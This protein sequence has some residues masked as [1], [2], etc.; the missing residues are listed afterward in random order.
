MGFGMTDWLLIGLLTAAIIFLALFLAYI[1]S[2]F[3]RSRKL[4]VFKEKRPKN[5]KKRKKWARQIKR[6]EKQ[7]KQC[8]KWIISFLLLSVAC[9]GAGYYIKRYQMTNLAEKDSNALVQGYFLVDTIEEQLSEAQ[10]AD[11][12]KK[13]QGTVYELSAR[14]SSFGATTPD[15]RLSKDGVLLLKRLYQSMKELGLNLTSISEE[16]IQDPTVL[17]EYLADIEKVKANQKKV[18]DYFRINESSLKQDM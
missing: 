6:I 12:A 4:A 17:E 14:L 13:V 10:T 3:V 11:S 2:F 15:S 18:F 9:G 8:I 16:T 7:R 1:V 5:K